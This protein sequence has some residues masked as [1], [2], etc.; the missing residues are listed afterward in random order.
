MPFDE[1]EVR[2][3]DGSTRMSVQEFLAIP[4]RQRIMYILDRS[5]DFYCRGELVDRGMALK[6]LRRGA[7]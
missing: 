3:P 2:N 6:A 1:V 4:L 5:L 7:A